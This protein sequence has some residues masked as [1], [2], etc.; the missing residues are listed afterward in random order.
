MKKMNINRKILGRIAAFHLSACILLGYVSFSA[1]GMPKNDKN[2]CNDGSFLC[3]EAI[4]LCKI[5]VNGQEGVV[6]GQEEVVNGQGEVVNGQ[7]EV[8]NGG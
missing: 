2:M 8:V 6:N 4:F 5:I 3:I 7:V 1:L